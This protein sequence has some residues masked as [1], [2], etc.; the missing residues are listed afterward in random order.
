MLF[1]AII[2]LHC[3]YHLV[4]TQ[5]TLPAGVRSVGVGTI[6]NRSREFGLDKTLAFAFER[7]VYR[8]GVLRLA[9]EPGAGDAV[10][11]GTIRAFRTRPVAFD[12]QDEAVEYETE[13]IVDLL[14]RR[15]SDGV[16]V[17]EGSELQAWEEYSVRVGIVVP[18]TSQFQQGTLDLNDLQQL[19]DIQLAETEKRL[20]IER[21][22][23]S[24][25]RDAHD[26]MLE[27]F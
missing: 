15:Q 10:L 9:E 18:S 20:A 24:I 13:M 2:S 6:E 25:V 27:D 4:G 11:T 23:E 22:V 26:R 7:E 8:R 17:W 16:V 21:L 3:G 14:L 19:T 1:P 5:R 12:A